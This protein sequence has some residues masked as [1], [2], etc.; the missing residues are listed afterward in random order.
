MKQ[1]EKIALARDQYDAGLTNGQS[2]ACIIIKQFP[3]GFTKEVSDK[4]RTITDSALAHVVDALTV[5]GV[6]K[7]YI[8]PFE[9]GYRAGLRNTF[10]DY[11]GDCMSRFIRVTQRIIQVG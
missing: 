4:I 7:R 10:A 9:R 11:A 5:N 3:D 2:I 6:Q 1:H 8:K